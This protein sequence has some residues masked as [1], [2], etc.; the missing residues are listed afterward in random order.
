MITIFLFLKKGVVEF[1]NLIKNENMIW[2]GEGR[3]DTID[4]Y[5]DR[6]LALMREAGCR[7]IFFGAETGNDAILKKMDKGGHSIGCADP[8][9]CSTYGQV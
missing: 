9:L 2:W 6:S 1:S 3:I 4:K 8:V 7:M 5:S